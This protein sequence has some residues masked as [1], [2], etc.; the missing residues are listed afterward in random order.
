MAEPEAIVARV[1]QEL[2][3]EQILAGHK[4]LIT[5]GLL[6]KRLILFVILP[7]IVLA[8]WVVL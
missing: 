4:I 5:A 3:E 1:C 6:E 2:L 7:I 8:K